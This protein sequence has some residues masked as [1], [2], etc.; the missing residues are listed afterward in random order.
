MYNFHKILSSHKI[1]LNISI[2]IILYLIFFEKII[3]NTKIQ[4]NNILNDVFLMIFWVIIQCNR[5][6]NL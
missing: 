6:V 4:H 5:N 2:L 3:K 1:L